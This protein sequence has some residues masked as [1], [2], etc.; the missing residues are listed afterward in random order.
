MACKYCFEDKHLQDRNTGEVR[1]IEIGFFLSG[2]F[3]KTTEK[4]TEKI[5]A[6]LDS[7]HKK[8]EFK[9]LNIDVYKRQGL[10]DK[11]KFSNRFPNVENHIQC[12]DQLDAKKKTEQIFKHLE[13][14][15]EDE[16]GQQV[17]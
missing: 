5:V 1:N 10:E 17:L 4:Y 13:S 16:P 12:K 2:A 8:V 11:W 9:H 14:F 7:P 3:V 6:R 15:H